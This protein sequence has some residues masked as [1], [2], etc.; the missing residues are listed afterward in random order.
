LGC[1]P[2]PRRA[3][4]H[5]PP[6]PE[7]MDLVALPSR[8]RVEE[9]QVE[10][11]GSVLVLRGE[12]RWH[13]LCGA[14]LQHYSRPSGL[15][16]ILAALPE[17]HS[18]F[19]KVSQNPFLVTNGMRFHPDSLSTEELQAHAWQSLEE[20]YRT[21]LTALGEQYE[22]ARAEGLG[23]DDLVQVAKAAA[24]GRVATL[25]IEA[26][27]QIMGW[28]DG[29]TGTIEFAQAGEARVSDLLDELGALTETMAGRVMVIP[30]QEMPRESG[31]AATYRY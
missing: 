26:D 22:Q 3:N 16:L 30:P 25:L 12:Y 2:M 15:P 18:R 21:R 1:G 10:S 17:H 11:R 29:T 23:S 6:W 7:R 5:V 13:C 20:R 28:L 14:I 27:R 4:A 8:C 24:S 31:L 19:H 9:A